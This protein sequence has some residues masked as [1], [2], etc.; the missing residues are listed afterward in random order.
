MLRRKVHVFGGIPDGER[1]FGESAGPSGAHRFRPENMEMKMSRKTVRWRNVRGGILAGAFA[2]CLWILPA[3]AVEPID[4]IPDGAQFAL[5]VPDMAAVQGKLKTFGDA[6]GIPIPDVMAEMRRDAGLEK[7]VKAAGPFL[8]V[9]QDLAPAL[10]S[11]QEPDV[12]GIMAVED[13]AAFLSNFPDA[14]PEAAGGLI[15]LNNPEGPKW[16]KF[17]GG[18]VAFSDGKEALESFRQSGES[19]IPERAGVEGKSCIKRAD[20]FAYINMESLAPLLT[21]HIDD[22]VETLTEELEATEE[23]NPMPGGPAAA[24]AMYRMY[25]DIAKAVVRDAQTLIVGLD[26]S[27]Q[28][29]GLT[30]ALHFKPESKVAGYLHLGSGHAG[31]QL[32]RLPEKPFIFALAFDGESVPLGRL[33]KRMLGSIPEEAEEEVFAGLK[34]KWVGLIDDFRKGAFV[35]YAP[36]QGAMMGGGLLNAAYV[37]EV[38]DPSAFRKAIRESLE[39][40]NGFTIPLPAEAAGDEAEGPAGITYATSYTPSALQ[41]DGVDVDQFRFSVNMPP[42]MMQ[43]MGPMAAILGMFMNYNGYVAVRGDQLIVT[44]TA[45]PAAMKELLQ[46]ADAGDALGTKGSIV[47]VRSTQ[48]PKNTAGEFYVGL[49]GIAEVVNMFV[50][51][52]GRPPIRVPADL[53]PIAGAIAPADGG[54]LYRLFVP[55]TTIRF[56]RRS[57]EDF[58]SVAPSEGAE[59]NVIPPPES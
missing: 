9:I 58:Q 31:E 19:R 41:I 37:Y 29:V 38:R 5:V 33:Y 17:F 27:R 47:K 51:M 25:A 50:G 32:A 55:S 34:E 18:F 26:L 40:L 20:A 46:S 35:A 14:G 7:G 8:L 13:R 42:E 23:I 24:V 1:A 52:M 53:P 6:V 4:L 15:M 44:T 56:V 30:K 16:A 59:P 3:D 12:V 22:L 48:L 11:D 28:G 36:P 49:D 10:E 57:V 21:A 54:L 39:E 45:D 2:A 43:Q